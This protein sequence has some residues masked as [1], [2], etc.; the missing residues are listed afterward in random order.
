MILDFFEDVYEATRSFNAYSFL[1]VLPIFILLS[2]VCGHQDFPVFRIQSFEANGIKNG[3]FA[4]S[5]TAEATVFIENAQRKCLIV[6]VDSLTPQSFLSALQ[7]YPLGIILILPEDISAMSEESKQAWMEIERMLFEQEMTIPIYFARDSEQVMHVL[8]Q[9]SSLSADRATSAAKAL[10]NA[11]FGNGYQI[12]VNAPVPSQMT[13]LKFTN[14]IAA[15]TNTQKNIDLSNIVFVAHYDALSPSPPLSFGTDS[16]GSGVAALIQMAKM[17]SRFYQS[18]R[19]EPNMDVHFILSGGGKFNFQGTK[20][21]L[22]QYESQQQQFLQR[23][24]FVICLD[25][26]GD[27]RTLYMHV[28]RVPKEGTHIHRFL[29]VLQ[30]VAESHGVPF[31]MVHKKINLA[32]NNLAWEHERFSLGKIP[33]TTLSSHNSH[34][35]PKRTSLL[36]TRSGVNDALIAEKVNVIQQALLNYMYNVS[37]VTTEQNPFSKFSGSADREQV[38][39]LLDYISSEPHS[40][41]TL[42]KS[43][44]YV[45]NLMKL[46][47]RYSRTLAAHE[48]LHDPKARGAEVVFYDQFQATASAYRVKPAV[49]DLF[50]SMAIAAYIGLVYLVV[51]C[52][53]M[54]HSRLQVMLLAPKLSALGGSPSLKAKNK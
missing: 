49:F 1:I 15:L 38:S 46:L 31:E 14:I 20:Q 37:D 21:I 40:S 9:L 7:M 13:N 18:S 50:L 8:D 5:I 34:F 17:L 25:S 24:E 4:S 47:G 51:L 19:T 45:Q 43:A 3:S 29:N 28:S 35:N 39:S 33:A 54:V 48:F 30:A 11:V 12:V 22:T 2:P 32:D 23:S 6:R 44:P 26:L 27:D 16:N 10:V 42:P 36:D 52:I 53:P 41:Q